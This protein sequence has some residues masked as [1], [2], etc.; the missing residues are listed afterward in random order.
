MN[1]TKTNT[2]DNTDTIEIDKIIEKDA[3]IRMKKVIEKNTKWHRL[4]KWFGKCITACAKKA[5]KYSTVSANK[6]AQCTISCTKKISKYI[7]AC[8]KQISRTK[9]SIIMN[10]KYNKIYG[11][12]RKSLMKITCSLARKNKIKEA[13]QFKKLDESVTSLKV[14]TSTMKKFCIF[15]VLIFGRTIALVKCV[16][17]FILNAITILCILVARVVYYTAKEII[18]SCKEIVLAFKD[19]IDNFKRF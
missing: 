7:T 4:Q 9:F 12:I 17:V 14:E 8:T 16:A 18:Y 10:A 11:E 19:A 1:D 6:I 13:G 5:G 15:F 3:T 2:D